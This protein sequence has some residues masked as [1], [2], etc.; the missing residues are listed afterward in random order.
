MFQSNK[1]KQGSGGEVGIYT[2]IISSMIAAIFLGLG[3]W[4]KNKPY[5]AI[6]AGLIFF[7]GMHLVEAILDPE[8]IFKSVI[9]KILVIFYLAKSLGDARQAQEMKRNFDNR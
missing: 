2:I 7:V 8:T 1:I 9:M 5:T 3:I 6:L 4:T